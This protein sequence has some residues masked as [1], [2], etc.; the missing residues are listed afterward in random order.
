MK[1]RSGTLNTS[2]LIC[3]LACG[4]II[5]FV[6]WLL[7]RVVT[8]NGNL[9]VEATYKLPEFA[10]LEKLPRLETGTYAVAIDG[11]IVAGQKSQEIRPTASMAKMILALAIMQKKPFDLGEKGE[12]ITINDEFYHIYQEYLKN[13]G[14]TSAVEVGE[15][16]S[17]YD[18]LASVM[19]VSSNNMADTLAIWAFGSLD[20]YQDYASEMLQGWGLGNT[21]IGIDASGFDESTTSSAS[22][23]AKIGTRVMVD[24]ILGEIVSL[25]NYDVPVAGT[26]TNTNAILGQYNISGVKTGYIG[27]VSGYC[28]TSGYRED[29]HIIVTTLMG[30]PSREIS[31]TNSLEITKTVQSEAPVTKLVSAGDEIGHLESWWTGKIIITATEDVYGIGWD[32]AITNVELAMAGQSGVLKITIGS[33]AYSVNVSAEEYDME[34]SLFDKIRHAFGWQNNTGPTQYAT[35]IEDTSAPVGSDQ[36]SEDIQQINA[37][38]DPAT[39]VPI[40]GANSDNCT[41]KY[42]SL[43]LVNPNFPVETD[44]IAARKSELVSIY[45]LY[46]IVEGNPG[47]GDNLLD[48]DAATHINDMVKAYEAE[49]PGHT[50]ET[51]SCFRAAGTNCGRLCAATGESDHHTGLTCDLIDP[52]YGTE[53]DTDDYAEH[54][55]WQW[56]RNNSYK[57]GFIDRFPEAWAGGPMS[58]PLNVDEN[59]STGLYETWHYRYVGIEHAT[60]IATGKYNNGEYDSLE[61]YLKARGL[62]SDVKAGT[63]K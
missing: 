13:D 29:D 40:T 50:L 26:L 35:T 41:I 46:G 8:T 42:G 56:L 48:A 20:N 5:A 23:L 1:K 14:S 21:R 59:G 31:F 17:E 44:F 7:M 37:E 36:P 63:C 9:V 45:S 55:D 57:Y 34:P 4:L 30:A 24:P 2:R 3:M 38:I 28:L 61:H 16:I 19:L 58:E 47:N 54:I 53:L 39:L 49:Y 33:R 62:I 6:T 25:K 12:I 51:R 32:D 52:S 43:M 22:D 15:E 10:S 60:N 18:A 27:D 11:E